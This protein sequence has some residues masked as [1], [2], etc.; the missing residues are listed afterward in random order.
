MANPFDPNTVYN[1]LKEY[2]VLPQWIQRRPHGAPSGEYGVDTHRLTAPLPEQGGLNTLSHEMTH[3][4]QSLM[5]AAAAEIRDRQWKNIQVS[6]EEMQFLQNYSKLM[7][8]VPGRIGQLNPRERDREQQERQQWVNALLKKDASSTPPSE[9]YLAYRTSPVEALAFG[10]GN[11]TEEN[12]KNHRFAAQLGRDERYSSHLDPTMAT[13]YSI[14]VDAF[15]RLPTDVREASA[16]KQKE[17]FESSRKNIPLDSI[18]RGRTVDN[19]AN[20]F[21]PAEVKNVK[22][23]K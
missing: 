22:S 4:S 23:R 20:P 7:V 2:G 19:Y 1:F 5:A 16:N 12:T 13:A 10:V 6:P 14:L 11:M 21:T 18:D 3:A 15:K 9:N 17:S 8:Y